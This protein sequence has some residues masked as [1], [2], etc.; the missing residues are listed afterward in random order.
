MQQKGRNRELEGGGESKDGER[1]KERERVCKVR[2]RDC[3]WH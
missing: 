2:E 1:E 3:E